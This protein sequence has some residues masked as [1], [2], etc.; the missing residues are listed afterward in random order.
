M[1]Q[2]NGKKLYKIHSGVNPF[3]VST[4]KPCIM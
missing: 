4:F 1:G 3:S 2:E